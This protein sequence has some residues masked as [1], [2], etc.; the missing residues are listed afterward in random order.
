MATGHAKGLL[1]E[2]WAVFFLML[3]GYRILSTRYK[4]PLGEIDIVA[5]RG[6]TLIFAEVKLRQKA[7]SAAESIHR[8]NQ[9]RVRRAAELYLQKHPRYNDCD[10]RCDAVIMTPGGWPRHIINAF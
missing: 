7:D 10:M 5:K 1:A 8:F 2:K 4:T 9:E 3:K 6:R